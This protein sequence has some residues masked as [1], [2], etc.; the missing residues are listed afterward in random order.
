MVEIKV[1]EVVLLLYKKGTLLVAIGGGGA[2]GRD[3]GSGLN[4][5]QQTGGNGGGMGM[6]GE[7]GKSPGGMDLLIMVLNLSLMGRYPHLMVLQGGIMFFTVTDWTGTG[8]NQNT[9]F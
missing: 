4:R 5:N 2:G 9:I 6:P 3:V 1:V 8:N 7:S